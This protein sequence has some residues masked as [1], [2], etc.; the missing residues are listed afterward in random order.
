MRGCERIPRPTAD[1]PCENFRNY[2]YLP[3]S[4][5]LVLWLG[6]Q[7]LNSYCSSSQEGVVAF[8]AHVGD[9]VA[10]MLLIPLFKRR[11]VRLFAPRRR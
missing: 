5:V 4:A 7:L 10:G 1:A 3:A 9:L 2:G 8:G 6:L 11:G